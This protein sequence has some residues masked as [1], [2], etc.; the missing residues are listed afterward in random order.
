MK[1]RIAT[2]AGIMIGFVTLASGCHHS[3]GCVG[4]S[5][6]AGSYGAL[7]QGAA[8]YNAAASPVSYPSGGPSSGSYNS[9]ET[10]P[11]SSSGD[12]ATRSASVFQG[13]GSR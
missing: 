4:G 8:S 5:C 13:S 3:R 9:Q 12:L 10:Y 1:T 11:P 2:L 6:S 7:R